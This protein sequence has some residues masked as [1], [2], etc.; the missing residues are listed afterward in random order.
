[1]HASLERFW[2]QEEIDTSSKT[3]SP[4]DQDCE[5]HFVRS[6][7]RDSTGR[8]IIRLPFK[9]SP[10]ELGHSESSARRMLNYSQKRFENNPEYF[11]A[12]SSFLEEYESLQ[13]M[14]QIDEN[15]PELATIYY[16]PHH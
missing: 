11:K 10:S 6:F 4:Q 1:M 3:P 5:D 9:R 15:S 12:H 13:H 16:L 7:S 8:Y 14:S 2:L